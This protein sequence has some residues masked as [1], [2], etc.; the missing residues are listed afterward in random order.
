MYA[1]LGFTCCDLPSSF[2]FSSFSFPLLSRSLKRISEA[3][4]HHGVESCNA[5]RR[6]PVFKK[7]LRSIA[8]GS[9][10]GGR[11]WDRRFINYKSHY[12]KLGISSCV[13]GSKGDN[14]RSPTRGTSFFTR[15]AFDPGILLKPLS[16]GRRKIPGRKSDSIRSSIFVQL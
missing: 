16:E 5:G 3:D 1:A 8:Y 14:E 9:G 6:P 15:L 10:G 13:R 7:F 11:E 4:S 12:T 2:S